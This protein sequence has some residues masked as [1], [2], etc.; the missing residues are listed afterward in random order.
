[1]IDAAGD[2]WAAL[3]RTTFRRTPIRRRLRVVDG[4]GRRKR[5]PLWSLVHVFWAAN[6]LRAHGVPVPL[7]DLAATIED[8]RRGDGYAATPGTGRRF[9]DDDAWLGLVELALGDRALAARIFAFV[10]SGE[11]PEGGVRW[12]EG[13]SAR[14]TCSTAS[15]AWLAAEL[16]ETS[17]ADRWMRWL[18][19][20]LR[21]D[22]ALY[23]DGF[24]E[25]RIDPAIRSYNQGAA[26]AT[27]RASLA[28]FDGERLWHE[29]P[30][31][32]AIWLRGLGSL[33]EVRAQTDD[34]RNRY[35]LRMMEEARDPATGLFTRGGIGTYDEAIAIH[36]AACVELLAMAD[37]A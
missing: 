8:Y 30:P 16:G 12:V 11:H 37:P 31:F 29:P 15:A 25:G 3:E 32:N 10:L 13:G 4:P 6:D 20:T 28:V 9:Y 36:Q 23:A 18:D 22:G 7:P 5:I 26:V 33:P 24:E 1:V 19:L 17:T 34:V 27:A 2:A 14:N 35:V 21:D